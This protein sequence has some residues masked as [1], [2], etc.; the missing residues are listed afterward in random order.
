MIV[1]SKNMEVG[2]LKAPKSFFLGQFKRLP[3][4][5]IRFTTSAED[6]FLHT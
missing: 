4:L 6:N 1:V 3:P 5:V 2:I